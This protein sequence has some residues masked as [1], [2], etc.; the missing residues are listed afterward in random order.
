MRRIDFKI[1]S[2]LLRVKKV[3]STEPRLARS[4]PHRSSTMAAYLDGR[5]SAMGESQTNYGEYASRS[6]LQNQATA[7]DSH[8]SPTNIGPLN[9]NIYTLRVLCVCVCGLSLLSP[10]LPPVI[11]A[12]AACDPAFSFFSF[13]SHRSRRVITLTC[14]RIII[15][16][17]YFRWYANA[18]NPFQVVQ[19]LR[20][21]ARRR[22]ACDT[23]YINI[24]ISNITNYLIVKQDTCSAMRSSVS[25]PIYRINFTV[26]ISPY[27]HN[28]VETCESITNSQTVRCDSDA[29]I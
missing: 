3:A 7:R 29:L 15:H 21:R 11:S 14:V 5:Q 27:A 25:C 18:V 24:C 28:I 23:L 9:R 8:V 10:N 17:L 22:E 2:C 6:A 20:L 16:S 1:C 13:L 12:N 4:R 26:R 19:I